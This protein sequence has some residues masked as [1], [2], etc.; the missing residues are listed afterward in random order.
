MLCVG[1]LP[2]ATGAGSTTRE[3]LDGGKSSANDGRHE[4][5]E[6]YLSM[7]GTVWM[8]TMSADAMLQR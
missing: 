8:L 1:S 2:T 6:L 7:S 5:A 3:L 4:P